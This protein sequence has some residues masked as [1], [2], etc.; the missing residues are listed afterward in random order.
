MPEIRDLILT[1]CSAAFGYALI[2]QVVYGYRNK[3]GSVTIQTSSITCAGLYTIAG[4]YLSLRLWFAAAACAVTAT[5]WLVLLI[6]RLIYGE[7]DGDE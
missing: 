3:I 2:P 5:L 7:P 4:V 6:Q 1:V